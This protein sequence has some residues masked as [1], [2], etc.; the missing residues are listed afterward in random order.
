MVAMTTGMVR[1][2]RQADKQALSGSSSEKQKV[3]IAGE[4]LPDA[5][6]R[7]I[8]STRMGIETGF[9]WE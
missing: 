9:S 8:W 7:R 6:S 1:A 4:G 5:L 3:R 2:S